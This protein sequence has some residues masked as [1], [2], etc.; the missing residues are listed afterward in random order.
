LIKVTLL[1]IIL[2]SLAVHLYKLHQRQQ[3]EKKRKLM[4]LQPLEK[5]V[6]IERVSVIIQILNLT[7]N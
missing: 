4:Y 7:I 2:L 5:P 6:D 1:L 3:V